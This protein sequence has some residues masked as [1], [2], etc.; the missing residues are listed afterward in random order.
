MDVL[1]YRSDELRETLGEVLEAPMTGTYP[2]APGAVPAAVLIPVLAA[3]E[4]PRLVFTR[5]TDTLSRHAGEISF[6]G[7]LVDDGERPAAAALRE[8][9]EELGLQASDVELL[10]GLPPV[11]T[12]VT[13]ILILPFVGWLRTDPRY[14][15]NA[16][17]IAEVLE[18]PIAD[19]TRR[20]TERWLEHE[21]RGFRSFVYDMDGAMI[22]GATAHVL[23]SLIERIAPGSDAGEEAAG[24][25]L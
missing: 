14:T 12:Y 15:P 22:W 24:G 19:L 7:G 17:E 20:G 3:T 16:A 4:E 18:F 5:R 2:S 10:G 1:M 25:L 21:G 11:H 13:G 8:A 6:P 23:R 9:E